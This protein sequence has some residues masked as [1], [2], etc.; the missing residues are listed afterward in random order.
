MVM[1]PLFTTYLMSS[2]EYLFRYAFFDMSYILFI[3]VTSVYSIL[4][5]VYEDLAL[6]I[7]IRASVEKPCISERVLKSH[8][9]PSECW[10]VIHIRTSVE[11][12]CT[13]VVTNVEVGLRHC[14]LRPITR[15]QHTYTHNFSN[16]LYVLSKNI[17]RK[18]PT[19]KLT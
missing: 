8:P 16:K 2:I 4:K 15:R 11:K 14:L 7:H 18:N 19:G 13:F 5:L 17:N 1:V 10:K 6:N 12:A 9:Y 3:T